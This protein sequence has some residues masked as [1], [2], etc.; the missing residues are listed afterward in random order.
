M[1]RSPG[2]NVTFDLLG[3]LHLAF[4]KKTAWAFKETIRGDIRVDPCGQ[5]RL[6]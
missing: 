5:L 6:R 4:G 2:V 1:E 3:D